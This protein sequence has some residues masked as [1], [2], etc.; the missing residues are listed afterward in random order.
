MTTDDATPARHHK[1]VVDHLYKV[2]G[3]DPEATIRRA[4][5]GESKDDIYAETRSVAAVADV[6]FTVEPGEIFVVMGLSGSGKSTLIRCL[7]RLIEPTRGAIRLDG[8]DVVS[9]SAEAL[10]ELRAH[11]LSMVFQHFALFPHKTVGENVEFGLKVR[12]VAP[13]ERR[14]KARRA[15]AQVGLEAYAEVPP[16]NLSGGMQQRVGLARGLAVDPDIM[17]MDEPFSALDPLIRRDMQEEL[18]ALQARL[19]MTI[20]F[21]THDLHEALRVGDRIAIMK[22]G[23]FV[24][25]GT[26][27]QIVAAPADDYVAAFTRDVD[28]GRVFRAGRL[29]KS[30]PAVTPDEAPAR[31]RRRCEEAGLSAIH[32]VD[33]DG[34]PQ[35]ILTRDELAND[36]GPGLGERM[37]R[38]FPVAGA[39]QELIGLYGACAEGLPIAVLDEAGRLHGTLEPLRVF[40]LLAGNGDGAAS[41]REPAPAKEA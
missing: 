30:A 11:K 28:R 1:I 20:I 39:D 25:T 23:R 10:R 4:E 14:D 15:L 29:A 24:Q 16:D 26:P 34:V 31:A 35:G 3:A 2:F 38:D 40:A 21:I 33:A 12:G 32:V 19:H 13:D 17:L 5:A 37:R 18:L 41:T 7:N 27:E 36:E 6:S 9:L 8:E 22:D